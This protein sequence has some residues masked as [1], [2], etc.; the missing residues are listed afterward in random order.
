MMY[1]LMFVMIVI[2]KEVV[3]YYVLPG[4]TVW[5]NDTLTGVGKVQVYRRNIRCIVH[6]AC[7]T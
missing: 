6:P 5:Y 7:R 2:Y 1:T 4:G 3:M